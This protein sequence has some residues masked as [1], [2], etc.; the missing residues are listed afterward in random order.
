MKVILDTNFF[1]L[2]VDFGVDIYTQLEGYELITL[3]SCVRELEYLS[4]RN[5][6][7]GLAL[8]ILKKKDIKTIRVNG[9]T[10]KAIIEYASKNN[11]I[12]ATN[13]KELIKRLNSNNIRVFRLYQRRLIK[14]DE[15]E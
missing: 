13:D 7:A 11:C 10:D 2:P 4:K 9:N 14:E 12:V 1:M 8:E 5:K 6:K 3:E 15:N